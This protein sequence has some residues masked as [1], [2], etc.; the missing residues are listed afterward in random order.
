MRAETLVHESVQAPDPKGLGEP[1]ESKPSGETAKTLCD[2]K[3]VPSVS[4]EIDGEAHE[5]ISNDAPRDM[6]VVA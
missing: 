5:G 3:P 2:C 1:E 4:P 6:F